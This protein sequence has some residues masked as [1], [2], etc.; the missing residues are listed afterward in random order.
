MPSKDHAKKLEQA[1]ASSKQNHKSPNVHQS[2]LAPPHLSK[3]PTPQQILQLQRTLGNQ[4]VMRLL[5]P[6]KTPPPPSHQPLPV[7]QRELEEI[8]QQYVSGGA[9]HRTKTWKLNKAIVAYNKLPEK[10]YPKRQKLLTQI[11]TLARNWIAAHPGEQGSAFNE[12]VSDSEP[13]DEIIRRIAATAF[14]ELQVVAKASAGEA[15]VG[16]AQQAQLGD[17]GGGAVAA[18]GVSNVATSNATDTSIASHTMGSELASAVMGPQEK[19]NIAAGIV[20]SFKDFFDSMKNPDNAALA[21]ATQFTTSSFLSHVGSIFVPGGS[22]GMAIVGYLDAKDTKKL[23]Q[24]EVVHYARQA[25]MDMGYQPNSLLDP[26]VKASDEEPSAASLELSE[27]EIQAGSYGQMSVEEQQSPREAGPSAEEEMAGAEAMLNT[28]VYAET[29][30][31][32]RYIDA[33]AKLIAEFASL[34]MT[35]GS[36][37]VPIVGLAKA[38]YDSSKA[39]ITALVTVGRKIKGFYKL[40]T[41][42]RGVNRYNS[43]AEVVEMAKAGDEHALNLLVALDPGGLVWKLKAKVL[44]E[45]YAGFP[46]WPKTTSRMKDLIAA[47][48]KQKDLPELIQL[49]ADKFKSVA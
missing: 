26:S 15:Q 12:R 33:F 7:I 14:D 39:A 37:F 21:D 25:G 19:T 49:V 40:V 13:K 35:L 43:A 38:A 2:S 17:I 30:V 16:S 29:K 41:G 47:M 6:D 28:M 31:S 22:F 32:R 42:T 34:A 10:E 1:Q 48:E 27:E 44:G 4:G 9:L 23:L 36:M 45:T 46:A 3:Q 18:W 20:T 11:Q 5:A 8:P 24:A